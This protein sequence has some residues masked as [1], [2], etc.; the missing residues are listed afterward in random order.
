MNLHYLSLNNYYQI[1]GVPQT[2]SMKLI[3]D[4]YRLLAKRYHPD[5]NAGN[6][7]AEAKFK[8]INEAYHHL[9]DA[10]R[11]KVYDRNL[12]YK[13][14]TKTTVKQEASYYEPPVKSEEEIKIDKHF[15]YLSFL[16]GIIIGVLLFSL[17]VDFIRSK[18]YR[19]QIPDAVYTVPSDKQANFIFNGKSAVKILIYE[20]ENSD[21]EVRFLNTDNQVVYTMPLN[22]FYDVYPI[23]KSD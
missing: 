20:N 1:L 19:L 7:D 5:K 4:Q 12:E 13:T 6:K 18:N 14:Y 9:S 10:Y 11:R 23:Y 3:K 16:L 21:D 2:A 8:L 17:I 15:E 22:E